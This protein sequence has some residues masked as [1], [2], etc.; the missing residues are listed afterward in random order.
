MFGS[1]PLFP[2]PPQHGEDGSDSPSLGGVGREMR[3]IPSSSE[4]HRY[5]DLVCRYYEDEQPKDI[6]P[7]PGTDL[8][9]VNEGEYAELLSNLVYGSSG[10][11]PV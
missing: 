5:Q 9:G 7:F 3:A 4:H 6:E 1:S 2:H 11:A 10:G 8:P